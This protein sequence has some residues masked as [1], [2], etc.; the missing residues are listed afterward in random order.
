MDLVLMVD[1]LV[2]AVNNSFSLFLLYLSRWISSASSPVWLILSV[3]LLI[4]TSGF[5]PVGHP[6][7]KK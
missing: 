3:L 6:E 1:D 4:D 2:T 5:S 7:R